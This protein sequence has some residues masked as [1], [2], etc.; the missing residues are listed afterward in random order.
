VLREEGD[1]IVTQEGRAARHHL[2]ENR[3]KRVEVG[4]GVQHPAQGLLGRHVGQGPDEHARLAET[5]AVEQ[6][7]EAEV[8]QLRDAIFGEPDVPRL[9]IAVDDPVA[10]SVLEGLAELIG[11]LQDLPQGKAVLLRPSEQLCQIA[12]GHVLG[13][14]VGL[15][16]FFAGVEDGDYVRMVA[17]PRH[18]LDLALHAGEPTFVQPLGLDDRDGN[19]AF[20]A[21]V[22][23]EIDALAGALAQDAPHAEAPAGK[24]WQPAAGL[25]LAVCSRG[26]RDGSATTAAVSVL[27]QARAVTGRAD[28]GHH[29]AGLPRVS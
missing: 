10:M 27:W 2:V 7:G 16:A 6:D 1:G 28:E 5:G 12:P 23:C 3:A 8:A 14:D 22:S 15:A 25:C 4:T 11:D 13:H 9:Q 20:E 26:R 21:A 17:E 29:K 24:G 19:I 18:R